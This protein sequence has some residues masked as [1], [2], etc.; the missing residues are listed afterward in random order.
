MIELCGVAATIVRPKKAEDTGAI[1]PLRS[2][3]A[4]PPL[5]LTKA[6]TFS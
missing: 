2:I 4:L 6:T 5:R 3:L 1:H